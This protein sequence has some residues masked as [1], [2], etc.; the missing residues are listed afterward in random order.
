MALSTANRALFAL[1]AAL[2]AGVAGG[3]AAQSDQALAQLPAGPKALLGEVAPDAASIAEIAGS[4]RTVEE[5]I[6]HL[7]SINTAMSEEQVGMLSEYL[8]LNLPA[9]VSGA[10]VPALVAS[11]PADGRDLFATTCFSCH[12]VVSYY[13]LQDRD[14]AG[15]MDI[16]AAP[17]HRRMLTGDHERETFSS[18]AAHAMPIAED[19]VPEAW[20]Q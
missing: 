10:D 4:T 8:A 19:Q 3:A 20:K 5:W 13:L 16:F 11:L 1:C 7:S 17:Y 12:G 6:V 15:W 9:E 2:I 14:Q 18:Y